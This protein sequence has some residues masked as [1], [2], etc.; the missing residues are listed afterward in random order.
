MINICSILCFYIITASIFML[1]STNP[2]NS[3]LFLIVVFFSI[4]F[5]FIFLN[6]DFIGILILIIYIGAIAV[7]FLFI[8]M[9]TNIKKI[10]RDTSTY[11]IVGILFLLI[12]FFQ[13]T[14]VLIDNFLDFSNFTIM[15][16]NYLFL[17]SDTVDEGSK[18]FLLYYMG[19]I[20][21]YTSPYLVIYSGLLLLMS[22]VAS[23]Y[24][25][26]FKNGFSMRKQY[27]DQ[28]WRNNKLYNILIY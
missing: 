5:L 6:A 1:L 28:L 21:F 20:L 7:L 17:E 14:Y 12:L 26:N 9:L 2:V 11:L 19:F 16:S 18:F 24:L 10:E 4:S 15:N 25:T 3:V 22:I 23:I 13:L 8:V 27:N